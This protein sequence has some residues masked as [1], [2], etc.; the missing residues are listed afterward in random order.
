MLKRH[1]L[2]RRCA[3]AQRRAARPARPQQLRWLPGA[4]APRKAAA[5]VA[6]ARLRGRRADAAVRRR[7]R[8][9]GRAVG[10]LA[11]G[12]LCVRLLYVFIRIVH[13]L[14]AAP[15]AHA[16]GPRGQAAAGRAAPAAAGAPRG[17]GPAG[18]RAGAR[19]A[20]G[21][22]EQQSACRPSAGCAAPYWPAVGR[23]PPRARREVRAGAPALVLQPLG[24]AVQAPEEPIGQQCAD[25]RRMRRRGRLEAR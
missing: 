17:A 21:A 4:G 8:R 19:T 11:I 13:A 10:R 7:P 2:V 1:G 18:S 5:Q 15:A 24:I 23:G 3:A 16:R 14:V 25:L 6:E 9:R 12:R 22:G 20:R